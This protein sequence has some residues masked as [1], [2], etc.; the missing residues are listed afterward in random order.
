MATT[1][2]ERNEEYIPKEVET[3][4]CMMCSSNKY[5]TH[6]IFGNKGQYRYVECNKCS[7]IYLNPRPLYNKE[8]TDIAYDDYGMENDIVKIG[9]NAPSAR[10]PIERYKVAIKALEKD[11]NKKGKILDLGCGTGEFLVAAHECGWEP[12]GIDI[13]K[14]MVEHINTNLG[15]KAKSGQ[16]QELDLYDWGQFD[17]IF[18]SHVIEHIPNPN[19]WMECFNKYLKDDGILLLNIPNQHAPEKKLQRFLKTI[20]LRNPVW[21]GWRTPD[22]LYEPHIKSMKYLLEKNNFELLNIHTYS[23]KEILNE[24]YGSNFF[25]KTLKWGSKIRLFASK[26]KN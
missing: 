16:F 23:S 11:F 26:K 5:K 2:T 9:P 15:F 4:I 24:S 20:K 7:N 8:F 25:H 10:G 17:V 12:Y 3:I 13:S 18:S 14:P 6:E 19:Q 22:H 21:E 1:L